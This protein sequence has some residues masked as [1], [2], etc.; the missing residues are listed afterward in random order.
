MASLTQSERIVLWLAGAALLLGL[1][2]GGTALLIPRQTARANP[3][4]I[5]VDADAGP[6]GDGSSWGDAYT[7]LQEGLKV[8]R[9]GD[10]IWVAE[11]VYY[12]ADS[13][14][15][16][17]AAFEIR[18][19][20]AL[21]GGF[22]GTEKE[23]DERDW[24]AHVT[25]LSGD[26]DRNDITDAN[27]VVT[28]TLNI[29][30]NNAYHVVTADGVPETAVLDGFTITAGYADGS[31]DLQDRGGGM[32]GVDS[33]PTVRHVTFSGNKAMTG[34]GGGMVNVGS[35]PTLTNVVFSGNR[36]TW[37]GGGMANS[38]TSSPTLTNVTFSGNRAVEGGAIHN[39]D[40]SPA[41]V[42][43]ILWGNEASTGAQIHNVYPSASDVKYSDVEGGYPG[44]A[45]IDSDPLF[46]APVAP[47]E[48]PTT[49]GN[50]RLQAGSPAVDGGL[51][52]AVPAAVSTD[53]DGSPR[54]VD[55][56]GDGSAVVDMGAYERQTPFSARVYLPLVLADH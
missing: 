18:A 27:G 35:H 54:I 56:D 17:A 39:A 28:R 9:P 48:A 37:G 45:N 16:R 26:L 49:T 19:G 50:Y 1:L 2:M 29:V 12:P 31:S 40:S 10:E 53:L 25:V 33:S 42:N 24:A 21:V 3:G 36:A 7:D 41:L 46:V 32:L 22:A 34:D 6:G 52:A 11:G 15:D 20:V 38:G 4:F 47:G 13:P 43:A 51:N 14:D 5:Y 8:A 44:T 30:G 23:R 55:G